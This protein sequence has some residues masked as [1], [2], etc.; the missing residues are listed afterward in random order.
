MEKILRE[1][2][3]GWSSTITFGKADDAEGWEKIVEEGENEME[4]YSLIP[5]GARQSL[6]RSRLGKLT[7]PTADEMLGRKS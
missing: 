3:S 1:I 2:G 5:Y 7:M 4:I 6:G